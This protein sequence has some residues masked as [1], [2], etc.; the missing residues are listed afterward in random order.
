MRGDK[1]LWFTTEWLVPALGESFIRL[2][3]AEA[4][5]RRLSKKRRECVSVSR[6]GRRHDKSMGCTV[7]STW[8]VMYYDCGRRH[9]MDDE[10]D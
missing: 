7:T 1:Q 6:H 9:L 5:A 8:P 3:D 4:A 2:H 10:E